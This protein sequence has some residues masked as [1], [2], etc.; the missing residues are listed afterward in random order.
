MT[1]QTLQK[2]F[3]GA[4]LNV[5]NLSIIFGGVSNLLPLVHLSVIYSTLHMYTIYMTLGPDIA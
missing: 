2:S 4:R 1:W 3:A 5:C